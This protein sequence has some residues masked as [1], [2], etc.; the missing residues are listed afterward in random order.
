MLSLEVA[1]KL[2]KGLG[3]LP[4][5]NVPA[6]R[7]NPCYNSID[8]ASLLPDRLVLQSR[9]DRPLLSSDTPTAAHN[10]VAFPPTLDLCRANIGKQKTKIKQIMSLRRRQILTAPPCHK[11]LAG[12]HLELPPPVDVAA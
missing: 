11:R 12:F 6:L 3:L 8:T 5:E 4:T 7:P 9:I 10:L 2:I 1:M